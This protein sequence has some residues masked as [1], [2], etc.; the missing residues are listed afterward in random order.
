RIRFRALRHF[1]TERHLAKPCMIADMT[2]EHRY[3]LIPAHFVV[4]CDG[5]QQ[6]RTIS[7]ENLELSAN[8]DQDEYG[9]RCDHKDGEPDGQ[10]QRRTRSP[11]FVMVRRR[12]SSRRQL[13]ANA[14][15]ASSRVGS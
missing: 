12:R 4:E 9:Y 5:L 11:L 13:L 2:A 8:K 6:Q 3:R 14:P 15:I 7:R 1:N 10:N